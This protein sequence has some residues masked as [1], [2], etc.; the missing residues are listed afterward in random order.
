M[1]VQYLIMAHWIHIVSAMAIDGNE[2]ND[3]RCL[4]FQYD[5]NDGIYSSNIELNAGLKN[6]NYQ[7]S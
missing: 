1:T 7:P 2:R 5:Y 3:Q 6:K 4:L